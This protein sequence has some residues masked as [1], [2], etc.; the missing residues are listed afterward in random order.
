MV[1]F[2]VKLLLITSLLLSI[3]PHYGEAG[4]STKLLA[5]TIQTSI[6]ATHHTAAFVDTN[7]R[8]NPPTEDPT[9][10]DA[11]LKQPKTPTHR[12]WGAASPGSIH[13]IL[14]VLHK[15]IQESRRP[16]SFF[17]RRP[18][19]NLKVV[20][21]HGREETEPQTSSTTTKFSAY[22]KPP[23]FF[24]LVARFFRLV[25][26]FSPLLP[27]APLSLFSSSFRSGVFYPVLS[28]CLGWCGP[29]FIK[30]GQWA[31][32]RSDMF[33]APLCHSLSTLHANAPAHSWPH[34]EKLV[35]ESLMEGGSCGDG[36]SAASCWDSVFESFASK[37]IA[38]GSIAQVHKA[39]IRNPDPDLPGTT[40]AV[41]VRHPLVAELIDRDFR[42]MRTVGGVVDKFSGGWLNVR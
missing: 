7:H 17:S 20:S 8:K 16:M 18:R 21:G 5:N 11:E 37:P 35:A 14:V 19:S 26:I 15:R 42:I 31:S 23:T 12:E 9:A 33:P 32:T 4:T 25:L 28:W 39:V 3:L 13:S 29:A 24:Q 27:L 30:W 41:K 36:E 40:V 2:V 38:S 22:V 10:F 6:P 34:T 1:L